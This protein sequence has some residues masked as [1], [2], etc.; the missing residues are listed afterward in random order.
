MRGRRLQSQPREGTSL[1]FARLLSRRAEKENSSVPLK[2]WV[3]RLLS[4]I[5]KILSVFSLNSKIGKKKKINNSIQR[6]ARF[7]VTGKCC[8]MIL[9]KVSSGLRLDLRS[10]L[11]AKKEGKK[12]TFLVMGPTVRTAYTLT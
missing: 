3:L 2:K 10:L 4:V 9:I 1:W 6:P 12:S 7:Q 5:Q 11:G 8:E